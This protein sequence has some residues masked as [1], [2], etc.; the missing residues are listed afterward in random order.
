MAIS[1]FKLLPFRFLHCIVNVLG[2][3]F[4]GFKRFWHAW[5]GRGTPK[6]VQKMAFFVKI[7]QSYFFQKFL[8]MPSEALEKL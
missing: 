6:I 7:D 5:F 3:L 8:I 1:F 4:H 2:H